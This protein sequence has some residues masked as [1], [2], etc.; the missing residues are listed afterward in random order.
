M[1]PFIWCKTR[2]VNQGAPEKCGLK[3]LWKWATKTFFFFRHLLRLFKNRHIVITYVMS[4]TG[5]VSLVKILLKSELIRAHLS[6][7]RLFSAYLRLLIGAHL[8][9]FS[10][11]IGSF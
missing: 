3:A 2:G 11:D 9:L 8:G 10:G 1:R 6:L 5:Y 4:Y 7:F